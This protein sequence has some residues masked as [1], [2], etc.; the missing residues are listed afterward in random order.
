MEKFDQRVDNYIAKSPD[1]A[2][3][4]LNYIR[5]VVH[6]AVPQVIET[7]KWG[8]P[9]FEYKGNV[10]GM[11]AF[12]QHCAFVLWHGSQLPD[13]HHILKKSE[14]GDMGQLG[15]ITKLE[16]LPSGS[17]LTEYL[18]AAVRLNEAGVKLKREKPVK[19]KLPLE[20]P[21]GL[22]AELDKNPKA[23][24]VFYAFSYSHKK[25][26]VEWITEAK[27][28]ATRSKRIATT[29]EWLSEDK[30]RNWKYQR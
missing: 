16:D 29:I 10:C 11:A 19:E 5:Q 12:K 26:Y 8:M 14:D 21:A 27:T 17:I 3:P 25:E 22:L 24:S 13:P 28:E 20:V 30:S 2:K 6:K 15:H 7:I 18:Q 23:S 4:V 1:F 9:F